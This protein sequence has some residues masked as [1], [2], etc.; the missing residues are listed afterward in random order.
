MQKFAIITAY[1]LIF[2]LTIGVG[3]NFNEIVTVKSVQAYKDL[4]MPIRA[5]LNQENPDSIVLDAPQ[6]CGQ[7]CKDYIKTQV[8]KAVAN[9][10]TPSSAIAP[11]LAKSKQTTYIPLSGPISTTSTDWVNAV[12]TEV[13]IDLTNDYSN[14]AYVTWEASLKIANA[15]GLALARLFDVTHG[16]AV[17]GSEVSVSSASYSSV[18]SGKLGLWAGNNKY[19]VQIKSQTSQEATFG[20]G[21]IKV[22]Y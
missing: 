19:V 22:V 4:I 9:L 15:S 1:I 18:S 6:G 13:N 12:G 11:Q 21:R 7:E 2:C 17:N 3:Y 8:T 5:F 20:S 10:P 16:I 14:G